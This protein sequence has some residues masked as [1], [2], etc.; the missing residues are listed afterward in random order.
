MTFHLLLKSWSW[1][2][3]NNEICLQHK[4]KQFGMNSSLSPGA[5]GCRSAP[6]GIGRTGGTWTWDSNRGLYSGIEGTQQ[7]CMKAPQI[8]GVT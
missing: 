1:V 6:R 8:R 7:S 2:R 4:D 3:N 5:K